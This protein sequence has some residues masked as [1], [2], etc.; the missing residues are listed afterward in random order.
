MWGIGLHALE[1]SVKT[2][3][4]LKLQKD[5]SKLGCFGSSKQISYLL[6]RAPIEVV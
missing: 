3:F 5:F 2:Q 4:T 6:G 1:I